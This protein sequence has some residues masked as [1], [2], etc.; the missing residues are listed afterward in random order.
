MPGG[1]GL[2]PFGFQFGYPSSALAGE[3]P[4]GLSSSRKIDGV[5]K[6]YVLNAQGGF[7]P[8]DDTDQRVLL[9]FSFAVVDTPFITPQSMREQE[10]RIR[11]ALTTSGLVAPRSPAIKIIKL[12]VDSPSYGV[13]RRTLVFKNLLANTQRTI[14]A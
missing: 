6:R 13:V 14:E 8:M 3:N 7:A 1:Y 4:S 10:Q 9:V 2:G 5:T 11:T 12:T